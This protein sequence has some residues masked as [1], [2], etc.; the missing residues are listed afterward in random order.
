MQLVLVFMFK[1]IVLTF[2]FAAN[3]LAWDHDGIPLSAYS[4]EPLA[5]QLSCSTPHFYVRHGQAD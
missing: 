1:P 2:F 3:L 5:N 4:D